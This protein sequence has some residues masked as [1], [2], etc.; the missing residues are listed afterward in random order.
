MLC[1]VGGNGPVAV[2]CRR[3]RCGR[4]GRRSAANLHQSRGRLH[5]NGKSACTALSSTADAKQIE[6]LPTRNQDVQPLQNVLSISTA[7]KNRYLLHFNSLHSLTQWTA[8]IRL[9]MFEHAS[10]Q[11]LYTGSLIAGKGKH[12]NNIRMIM[13]RARYPSEDWARVRFGAGTPWRRCWCVIEPPNEKEYAKANKTSLKKKSAYERPA[14]PK[15]D[16]KFYDTKKTKKAVPIATITDAY[17]AYAIYPQSKPLIDQSTLVKVEGKITIHS[18]PESKTEGFVFVMP[19]VHPAVSGFEIMLRWLF[20]VHD[21]FHLYGRPARLIADTLDPRGLMFAMPTDRRYGYL[22]IIDVAGLIHTNGS[23]RWTEREWR[24]QLKE[25][26]SRRMQANA[27]RRDSNTFSRNHRQS[28]GS[29][30]ES[31]LGVRYDDNAS[32]RSQPANQPSEAVFAAPAQAE[33]APPG[34]PFPI[35]SQHNRSASEN[36]TARSPKKSSRT[37]NDSYR[38]AG[39]SMEQDMNGQRPL[40]PPLVPAPA[41]PGSSQPYR[42][43]NGRQNG[44]EQM[45]SRNSSDT[46]LQGPHTNPEE[47]NGDVGEL[48]PITPVVAPPTM[49]HE[50]GDRPRTRPAERPDLRR[51]KSRM[52]TATLAQMTEA[53]R[54]NSNGPATAGATAAWKAREGMASGDSTARG[55]IQTPI[56]TVRNPANQSLLA[57]GMVVRSP[58]SLLP[59]HRVDSGSRASSGQSIARKP[60]PASRNASEHSITREASRGQDLPPLPPPPSA[61]NQSIDMHS[62]SLVPGGAVLTKDPSPG[63]GSQRENPF[64]DTASTDSPDYESTDTRESEKSVYKPRTGALKIIG[65]PDHSDGP[66]NVDGSIPDVD[67]GPT[68]RLNPGSSRPTTPGGMPTGR[69]SPFGSS[70]IS[71]QTPDDKRASPNAKAGAKAER[72][73]NPS[74]S[75]SYNQDQRQSMI[76]QPGTVL[77]SG[78]QSP[79]P[80]S[81][82]AEEFVQQRAAT[83]RLPSGYAPRRNQSSGNVE[84]P[85]SG[86]FSKREALI[87]QQQRNASPTM[88]QQQQGDYTAKLSAR[89]QEHVSKMTGMPL[90]SMPPRSRTPDPSVGLIGAIE[91]REQEKRNIKEGVSGQMVQAAIAQRQQHERQPS[92][93]VP[94]QAQYAAQMAYGGYQG[95]QQHYY[96]GPPAQPQQ[97]YYGGQAPPQQA[98][99]PPNQFARQVQGQNQYYGQQPQQQPQWQPSQPAHTQQRYSGYYG[100]DGEQQDPYRR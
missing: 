52:S 27:T 63:R 96:G 12:L 32:I 64:A 98:P 51:E 56:D 92:Y 86:S 100:P 49:Q 93:G 95:Q 94:S 77:G 97:Q 84:R 29:R 57:A 40:P 62:R 37:Q 17:S 13:E 73:G 36:V 66:R 79:G 81:L 99:W 46:E 22:D 90:V 50:T 75:A 25:I 69:K 30:L 7:G 91:A 53:S 70:P 2:G 74:R 23:E 59:P 11:E 4:S 67:F 34:A 88:M 26:T 39:M 5:Q 68:Q 87:R 58:E 47:L 85:L 55:V 60:L 48:A 31:R 72:P 76:W 10:L 3:S 16:I 35:P 54:M 45:D 41:P 89:E 28:T 61:A 82:T 6:T 1:T 78:R 21:T 44:L 18:N 71:F 83:A 24:K 42:R 9:S 38:P 43:P 14:V 33:T 8:G 15:G 80:A 20:P 65:N 19:E